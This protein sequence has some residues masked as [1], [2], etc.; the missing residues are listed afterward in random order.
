MKEKIIE[1]LNNNTWNENEVPKRYFD[2]IA[3]E[4]IEAIK[5]ENTATDFEHND[6]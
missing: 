2:R 3:D 1:I 6:Y 5:Q 4:I